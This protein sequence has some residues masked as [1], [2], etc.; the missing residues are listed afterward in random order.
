R[1]AQE[2]PWAS[3]TS[4]HTPS[5]PLRTGEV[6]LQCSNPALGNRAVR[7]RRARCHEGECRGLTGQARLRPRTARLGTMLARRRQRAY[8]TGSAALGQPFAQAR[9]AVLR[10]RFAPKPGRHRLPPT[11]ASAVTERFPAVVHGELRGR[12]G[13]RETNAYGRRETD[14]SSMQAASG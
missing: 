13:T 9:D 1:G 12:P 6:H 3:R 10:A 7:L 5:A 2:G 14:A 8:S 11:P 4:E